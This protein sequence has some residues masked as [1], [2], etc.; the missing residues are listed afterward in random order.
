[1]RSGL[2]GRRR[3]GA[4]RGRGGVE[5]RGDRGTVGRR[6]DRRR[7]R[8]LVARA[9]L[10]VAVGLTLEL[11]DPRLERA[12]D[13]A[14]ER[15]D[16][17]QRG[18]ELGAQPAQLRAEAGL[19]RRAV[20]VGGGELLV[21]GRELV[22]QVAGR[23]QVI[24]ALR[25]HGRLGDAVAVAQRG[26]LGAQGELLLV[27]RLE[28]GGER[29]LRVARA[30]LGVGEPLAALGRRHPRRVAIGRQRGPVRI[31]RRG[32]PM[33]VAERVGQ[34]DAGEPLAI[35][36][37]V[38]CG[39]CDGLGAVD[40]LDALELG[41]RRL[42]LRGRPG[43]RPA[44]LRQGRVERREPAVEIGGAG[45]G[46][47][48]DVLELRADPG[49]LRR[50]RRQ[51]AVAG[52]Q[53]LADRHMRLALGRQLAGHHVELAA[54]LAGRSLRGGGPL[55]LGRQ[56][57]VGARADRGGVRRG[58][59]AGESHLLGGLLA[60][61]ER[62]GRGGG[63]RLLAR[64]QLLRELVRTGA[65]VARAGERDLV[66]GAQQLRPARAA[67]SAGWA[68]RSELLAELGGKRD[69]SSRCGE[70]DGSAARSS[71]LRRAGAARRAP[72]ASA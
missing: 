67:S 66:G 45:G 56:C 25:V 42:E 14:F 23:R 59:L 39:A 61:G 21:R 5:L 12:D 28:L 3:A 62:L 55:A 48:P 30:L 15:R 71:S 10:E 29:A 6:G 1:M 33:G 7:R 20:G 50:D 44:L 18:I 40:R 43:V 60:H 34:R 24:V 57:L 68:E 26:Q 53:P 17:L 72:R 54:G 27:D 37:L 9:A 13:L 35:E 11:G 49:E 69:C 36:L 16:P 4:E 41:A 38:E 31:R 52:L 46:V 19:D 63:E 51:L 70:R 2:G 58:A 8:R 65:L 64:L 22:A 32:L 47:G